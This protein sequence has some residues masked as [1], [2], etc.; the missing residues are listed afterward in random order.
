MG[1]SRGRHAGQLERRTVTQ[2]PLRPGSSVGYQVNQLARLFEVALRSLIAPYRVPSCRLRDMRSSPRLPAGSPPHGSSPS[3][4]RR[5]P[6]WQLTS[7]FGT[8]VHLTFSGAG[9]GGAGNGERNGEVFPSHE[10]AV[11]S[12]SG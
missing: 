10:G 7:I 2:A 9:R 1:L 3:S 8:E 4:I 6:A 5:S 11:T 12:S